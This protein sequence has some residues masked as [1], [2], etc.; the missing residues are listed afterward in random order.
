MS[1]FFSIIKQITIIKKII[2]TINF[3]MQLYILNCSLSKEIC[4]YSK[5]CWCMFFLKKEPFLMISIFYLN[6]KLVDVFFS[7]HIKYFS[8]TSKKYQ[9]LKSAVYITHISLTQQMIIFHNNYGLNCKW[10]KNNQLTYIFI[11]IIWNTQFKHTYK[12]QTY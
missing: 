8:H 4:Y 7:I 6:K 10:K 2:H 1:C 3:H 5:L 9:I 12:K 11:N